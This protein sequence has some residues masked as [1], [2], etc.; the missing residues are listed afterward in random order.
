MQQDRYLTWI[1]LNL[2]GSEVHQEIPISIK[3]RPSLFCLFQLPVCQY[4]IDLRSQILK[5]GARRLLPSDHGADIRG[6][7]ELHPPRERHNVCLSAP[8]E[9]P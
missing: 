6:S 9:H 2:G 7:S 4:S 5:F 3:P 8:V 1:F